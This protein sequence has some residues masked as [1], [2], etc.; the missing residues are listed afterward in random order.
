METEPYWES[1]SS[2]KTFP[3]VDTGAAVA[4]AN[5]GPSPSAPSAGPWAL[6]FPSTLRTHFLALVSKGFR[7]RVGPFWFEAVRRAD[8]PGFWRRNSGKHAQGQSLI[9]ESTRKLVATL[10]SARYADVPDASTKAERHEVAKGERRGGPAYRL[11]CR[12]G[13]Q[14]VVYEATSVVSPLRVTAARVQMEG[15]SA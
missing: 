12:V 8:F 13:P 10:P 11:W 15:G 14:D 1:R 9:P 2:R 7:R 3:K 5:F 4:N 6:N